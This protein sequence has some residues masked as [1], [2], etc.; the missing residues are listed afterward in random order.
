MHRS[1]ISLARAIDAS[2]L[3]ILNAGFIS[4]SIAIERFTVMPY[5]NVE[6]L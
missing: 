4:G 6:F 2:P 1:V 5:I 3:D